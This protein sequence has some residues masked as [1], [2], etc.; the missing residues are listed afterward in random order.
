[1][2]TIQA[3]ENL[4][5]VLY[6]RWPTKDETTFFKDDFFKFLINGCVFD[7]FFTNSFNI[8]FKD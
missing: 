7:S 1:M 5:I 8:S 6:T 2:F 4:F 3:G